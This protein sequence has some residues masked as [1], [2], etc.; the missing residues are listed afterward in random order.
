MG[1]G[2][3]EP[4]SGVDQLWSCLGGRF[5]AGAGKALGYPKDDDGRRSGDPHRQTVCSGVQLSTAWVSISNQATATST[6]I[7]SLTDNWA[8]LNGDFNNDHTLF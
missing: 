8:S 3:R 2:L 1:L 4:L 6:V 5:R 7:W